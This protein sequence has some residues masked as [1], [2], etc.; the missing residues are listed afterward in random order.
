M[1][2]IFRR[3]RGRAAGHIV[4]VNPQLVRAIEP[5]VWGGSDI[6]FSDVHV[7]TS[8][9]P[10]ET[11]Q[12]L[13]EGKLRLCRM[14]LCDRLTPRNYETLCERCRDRLLLGDFDG[15]SSNFDGASSD[16]DGEPA[17]QEVVA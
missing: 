15:R 13:L 2:I 16:F 10:Q 5:L 6:H 12:Q 7:L 11:V 17:L 4:T 14:P 8:R 9:D 1:S 3:I